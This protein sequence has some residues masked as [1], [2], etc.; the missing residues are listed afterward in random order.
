MKNGGVKSEIHRVHNE[1]TK[2]I[3]DYNICHTTL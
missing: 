2:I 3:E 1:I